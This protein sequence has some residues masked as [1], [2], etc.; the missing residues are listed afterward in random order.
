VARFPIEACGSCN[1]PVV[2][3]RTKNGKTTPVNAEPSDDGN[4]RL[5]Y[6]NGRPFA[7]VVSA[8]RLAAGVSEPLRTSHFATC[9]DAPRWRSRKR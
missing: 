5:T 8:A 4:I 3:A 6:I 1:A 7:D 2:F 9:R